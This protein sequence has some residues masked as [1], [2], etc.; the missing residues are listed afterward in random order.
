MTDTTARTGPGRTGCGLRQR[1]K[2]RTRVA[3]AR[4]AM[5]LFTTQGYEATTVDEIAEACEVSQRTFFRYFAGKEA[6]AFVIEELVE[7][8]FT[9]AVLARPA[10][11]PPLR[12]LRA[13]I[14]QTWDQLDVVM[15]DVIP[16]ELHLRMHQVIESTPAL[17]AVRLRR[18]AQLE[19][20]ITEAVARREGLDPATDVRPRVLV[21]AFGGVAQAASRSWGSQP[22]L[23]VE[24]VRRSFEHHLAAIGPELLGDWRRPT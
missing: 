22:D 8:Q 24:A 5:E 11:E 6:A 1:K 18:Q 3:L 15:R 4:A 9:A 14:L 23:S 17:L 2:E 7:E 10:D 19:L 13:A 16:V 20:R 12:A 21:A